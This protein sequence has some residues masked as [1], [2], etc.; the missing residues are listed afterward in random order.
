MTVRIHHIGLSKER[1]GQIPAAERNLFVLLGHAANEVGV[2][3]KL[4]HYCAGNHSEEP[5]LEKAEHT[6]ALLLARLLTGKIYEFW[7]LLQTGYFRSVLSRTY[8]D[9]LDDEARSALDA[10]K[11][12]FGQDNL[13]ARVRNG[14]AFHYD[15]QQIENGF[16]TVLES[17]PLDI[18]LSEP[19]ANSLYAFAD[20]IAGR[21]MLEA[22]CPSDP[23]KAFAMLIS[24]IPCCRLDQHHHGRTY[25]EVS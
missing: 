9:A 1:L 11:R 21:A 4:F 8:H 24:E 6:Q 2:L 22:I 13:V 5:I 12:Y 20:T 16:Q 18:C 25:D 3:A 15:V 17:E 19:N 7:N 14:H 23:E 10:M